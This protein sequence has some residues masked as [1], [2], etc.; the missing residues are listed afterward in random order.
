MARYSG[1]WSLSSMWT[2]MMSRAHLKSAISRYRVEGG[3]YLKNTGGW[4]C[5]QSAMARHSG[6]W[7]VS[8]MWT[9]MGTANL[10]SAISR[11]R[12]E[13]GAALSILG[14]WSWPQSAILRYSVEAR[15]YSA[16]LL[17][18][19]AHLVN[20]QRQILCGGWGL[21]LLHAQQRGHSGGQ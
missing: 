2:L 6:K 17:E 11:Y 5:P 7:S 3:A 18:G 16:N 21:E 10:K 4:S 13:G 1:K 8:S 20:Q 9:L 12:V 15:A 19:W 14:R